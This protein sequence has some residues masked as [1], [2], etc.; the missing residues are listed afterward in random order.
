MNP[1]PSERDQVKSIGCLI[2]V[3]AAFVYVVIKLVF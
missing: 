2:A 1:E 3:I